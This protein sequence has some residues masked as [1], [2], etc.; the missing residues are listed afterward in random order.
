MRKNARE[1]QYADCVPT[2]RTGAGVS[3]FVEAET[4]SWTIEDGSL[5]TTKS[6]GPVARNE[7]A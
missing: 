7:R 5:M 3:G 2:L 6:R 1:M 4:R